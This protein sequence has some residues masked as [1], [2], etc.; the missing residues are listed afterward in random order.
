[1][2]KLTKQVLD[3]GYADRVLTERQLAR[4]LGGSDDRRY[5]L[6]K[7]AMQA[8][9]LVQIKRGHYV[10]AD[11][12]RTHPPHPF[13]L[14]QAV[15]VGS[16]VSMETALAFHGWIPEAV[17]TTVSVTPGRKSKELDHSAFGR[18]SFYPLALHKSAFLVGVE[19]R[20]ISNQTVLV[21]RPLR[22][23]LDLAAYKKLKWDGIGWVMNGM[24]IDQDHLVQTP[25]REFVALRKVYKHKAVL[26]FLEQL[27]KE[28]ALLKTY[29]KAV[30]KEDLLQ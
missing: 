9:S 19:R 1:M 8:G 4:I 13:R 30:T 3:A 26:E 28:V 29:R 14:A 25:K 21:A 20:S 16:Y 6:V 2:D 11:R 22:A 10:L 15:V 27:E 7:R 24:R 12:Y 18:F 23:L 5:G 17:F